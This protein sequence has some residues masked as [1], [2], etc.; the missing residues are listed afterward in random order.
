ML[1]KF[2]LIENLALIL[3]AILVG[4]IV[5]FVAQI[6]MYAAK[7]VFNFLFFNETLELTILVEE[8]SFNLV[9]LLICIPASIL[10]SFN[11]YLS[12]LPRW[13]GPADTIYASH[14]KAGTLDM[15]GGFTST[16]ASFISICGGA[17]VG[18]Y[19]PLVHF[20]QLFQHFSED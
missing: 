8:Y 7:V 5:S 14:T 2:K 3:V 1:K 6:F 17:S 11:L 19:G 18:I 4:I 13:Y 20:A 15:K 10:D 16:L 9:P 12:K